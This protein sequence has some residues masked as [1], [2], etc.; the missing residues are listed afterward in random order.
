MLVAKPIKNETTELV[1]PITLERGLRYS[2]SAKVEYT[3][4]GGPA[5]I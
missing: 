2:I 4:C 1:L 3:N 5:W